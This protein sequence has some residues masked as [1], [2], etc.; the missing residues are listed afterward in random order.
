MKKWYGLLAASVL[1][2]GVAACGDSSL[3]A[4]EAPRFDGGH[5]FGSGNRT[6]S[7]FTV[8]TAGDTTSA[9]SVTADRGGFGIG[10]GN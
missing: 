5:G 8:T 10:S 7:T 4:P 1:C 9:P 3:V 2:M 6:G